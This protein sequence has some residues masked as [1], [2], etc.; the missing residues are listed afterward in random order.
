MSDSPTIIIEKDGMAVEIL[1]LGASVVSIRPRGAPHSM[2]LSMPLDQYG[3]ANQ[4]Y[5]G[6]SVGR[7][8]NRIARG[9]FDL[10][11][12]SYQLSIN[13]GVNHLHGGTGGFSTQEWSIL[14]R[15]PSRAVLTT[16]AKDGDDGYPGNLY[17]RA[18]FTV[19]A[20]DA[21]EIA[22][23]AVTDR[24]T[25]ANLT[26]HLYFNLDGTGD[27]L[28]HDL[29]VPAG[30]YLPVDETT[31]PTGEIASVA[32]TRFDFCEG[33]RLADRPEGLDHNF[34]LYSHRSMNPRPAATLRSERSGWTLEMTT[35]EPG[36]Q[37]YDGAK[38]DGSQSHADGRPIEAFAGLALEPQI[39]PD[40]PNRPSFPTALL[41]PG[42]TYRSVSRYRFIQGS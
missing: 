16:T 18:I 11:G 30:H 7:F 25:I 24:P 39:W 12:R 40:A 35:T 20:G 2:V 27:V 21:L 1:A 14:E 37:V 15:S 5:A 17:A 3:A 19:L 32:G 29:T 10:A 33:R 31:M 13:D 4:S 36:L 8:A 28:G 23:E 22:Y 9:R 41:L 38:F 42:E 34:C 26:S 6:A